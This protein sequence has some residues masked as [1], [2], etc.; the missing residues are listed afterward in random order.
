MMSVSLSF[1]V[2][3]PKHGISM[4]KEKILDHKVNDRPWYSPKGKQN[5][6]RKLDVLL[7]FVEL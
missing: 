7:L 1:W 3:P 2:L 5:S 6:F 4:N